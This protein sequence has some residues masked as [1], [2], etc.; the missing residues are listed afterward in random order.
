MHPH[1]PAR[2]IWWVA[3]GSAG[4]GARYVRLRVRV[5]RTARRAYAPD[6]TGELLRLQ[7]LYGYNAHS[8]VSIAPGA[9]LW[10]ADEIDGAVIYN[11]FGRVWLAAGDPLSHPDESCE[12]ARQFVAAARRQRKIAVF[13]P[14]SERFAR[15]AVAAGLCAVKVGASPYF[16]LATWG[17]RGDRAKNMRSGVNRASRAGIEIEALET[18]GE[19]FRQEAAALCRAWLQTRRAAASFGW[20]FALDPLRHAAHKKFFAARDRAGALVGLLAA[21]PIPARDGWY[22]EDVLR[23]P[24][25][26]HGTADLLVVE[27]L[28]R[29]RDDGA[30]LATLGTSL[31]AADGDDDVSTDSHAQTRRALRLCAS[32]LGAFYNFAGL[33]RFK[34]KFAPTWWESEY[35]LAPP[36]ATV[37]PRVAYA[38]TRAVVPGGGVRLVARQLARGRARR[39]SV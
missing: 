2:D 8:L 25:A 5:A 26:P 37:A 36:G 15:A 20:L 1:I 7:T 16:D 34:A 4:Y 28:R 29:L 33:R 35:V 17:P 21:S 6:P 31:L 12:L 13:A 18:V 39:A 30:R 9:S 24:D 32:H 22:L 27:A 23:L 11:K 38:L 3:A 14:A 10:S 19:D